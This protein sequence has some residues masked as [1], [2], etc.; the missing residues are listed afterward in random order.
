MLEVYHG[1]NAEF[2]VFDKS[3]IG[4]NFSDSYGGFYFTNKESS[5]RYY[6]GRGRGQNR[7]LLS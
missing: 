1:T 7:L 6:A 2:T 5:A 3:K 4:K